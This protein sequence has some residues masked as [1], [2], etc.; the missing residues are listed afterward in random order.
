[1][2]LEKLWEAVRM[3]LL[4]EEFVKSLDL[5]EDT[6]GIKGSKVLVAKNYAKWLFGEIDKLEVVEID[7]DEKTIR[8]F[9]RKR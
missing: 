7:L 1:M 5:Y 3:G 4:E 9:E 8:V 2:I 6:I